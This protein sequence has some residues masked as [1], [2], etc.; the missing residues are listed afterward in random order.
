MHP[1][2]FRFLFLLVVL[3]GDLLT[4]AQSNLQSSASTA[5]IQ[6]NSF[7][8]EEAYNQEDGVIQHIST[9]ERLTNSR[10]WVYTQ[11]DEWPV[12]T[13]KHQVSVTLAATHAGSFAGSGAG[14]GD[15][16]FNYRYQLVGSGETRVA[17]A[18]RLSVL[19]PTGNHKFG[20][21]S[22]G[23]GWQTNL[24]LSIQHTA[25]WVTHWN[26]GATWIPH[27]L[28]QQR[29]YATTTAVN[30][31]QSIVWLARPRLNFLLE[32]LWTSSE[33]VVGPHKAERSQDLY[34]S[35]GVR[36]AYNLSRGLQIVPGV[37]APIGIGP[38]AG[39]KGVI[40]Y[41]SFE[42]PFGLAHSQAR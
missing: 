22:G 10:D 1:H 7:L 42:H 28:H 30:L 39:E 41:L 36:W 34:V 11:T 21:G 20:R 32:T 40:F 18:P 31:G 6:D 12:R 15:T 3:F 2:F 5:P 13:Y 19:L 9:F 35:P 33:Q 17:V 4:Q 23:V 25:H 14:W 29:E 8:I 37:A 27:A 38:C 24:P 16:A 26:A